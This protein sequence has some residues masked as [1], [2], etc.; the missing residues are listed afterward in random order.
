[1]ML[2][3]AVTF[4][5]LMLM[6]IAWGVQQL[7]GSMLRS[8]MMESILLPGTLVARLGHLVGC[9]MTGAA[10]EGAAHDEAEESDEPEPRLRPRPPVIG[11]IFLALLPMMAC[12]VGLACVM[13]G[14]GR[15][16]VGRV[17]EPTME[18]SVPTT[19]AGAWQ[20]LRDM[21]TLTEHMVG[22]LTSAE[23]WRW[24]SWLFLY[25]VV[26]LAVRMAPLP[27]TLRGAVGATVVLGL[28][29]ALFGQLFP[30]A[31]DR[32]RQG[33]EVLSFAVAVLL[34]LLLLGLIIRGTMSLARVL[35][36]PES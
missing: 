2:Y 4:W 25:L 34:F 7:W 35:I 11:P 10:M 22:T 14:L 36:T 3:A 30:Q 28:V 29:S 20:M 15:D 17:G 24:Q 18:M 32:I 33:W 8:W 12:M 6:L 19:T 23:F 13:N 31:Q 26:C 1:M 9:V 27:G 21:I 16:M 5:M